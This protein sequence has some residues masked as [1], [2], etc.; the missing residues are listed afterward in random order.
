MYRLRNSEKR[1]PR[2]RS[3]G[4]GD[5]FCCYDDPNGTCDLGPQLCG[6]GWYPW[7]SWQAI[8]IV[9]PEAGSGFLQFPG[10]N[11]PGFSTL[12]CESGS[13]LTSAGNCYDTFSG[14]ASTPIATPPAGGTKI[15][16]VIIGGSD[17]TT[18]AN[19]GTGAQTSTTDASSSPVLQQPSLAILGLGIAGIMLLGLLVNR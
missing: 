11:L 16:T 12:A 14:T 5:P 7:D 2:I 8:G 13:F 4:L 9:P 19:T 10:Q 15:P 6:P 18:V 17:L 1:I 3:R